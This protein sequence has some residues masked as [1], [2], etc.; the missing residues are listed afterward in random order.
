MSPARAVYFSHG[1]ESGPWGTKIRRLAQVA[2]GR[3]FGVESIDYQDLRDPDARVQRLLASGAEG[4]GYVV[5]VGSSM[6]GYV[7][8]VA[9]GVLK[10]KGLFLMAPA[11]Y[12]AGYA[13][14]DPV[15]HADLVAIVHGWRDETI[16]VE[17]SIRF[18]Q[19]HRAQLHL[20]D[21]DHRL[22]EQL[23]WIAALFSAFLERI[24]PPEPGAPGYGGLQID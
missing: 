10:P 15:P 19:K 14:Q 9:S 18:A 4:A 22:M 1:R 20:V 8:T 16:P 5:L 24:D 6:G 17:N 3:G 12:V 23:E 7:A 2:E 13:D 21:G 11:L